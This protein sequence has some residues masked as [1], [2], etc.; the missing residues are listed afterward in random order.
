M[1][2]L[3]EFVML[4]GQRWDL[5]KSPTPG[6]SSENYGYCDPY[7]R[8]IEIRTEL[9]PEAE[10]DTLLHEIAHAY[11]FMIDLT[12]IPPEVWETVVQLISVITI[13]VNRNNPWITQLLV[14]NK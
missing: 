8:L 14:L 6:K 7:Q 2:D 9:H 11:Q 4:M 12:H 10:L 3:P 13:D 1:A 5:R